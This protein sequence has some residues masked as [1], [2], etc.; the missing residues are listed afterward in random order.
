MGGYIGG[1]VAIIDSVRLVRAQLE[2]RALEEERP[3]RL[4]RAF[5][6]LGERFA[7]IA[8]NARAFSA[9]REVVQDPASVGD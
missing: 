6:A 8:K 7:S 2:Y 3:S 9:H 1:Y 5:V 4:R